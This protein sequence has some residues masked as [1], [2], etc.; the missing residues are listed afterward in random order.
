MKKKWLLPTIIFLIIGGSFFGYRTYSENVKQQAYDDLRK[1]WVEALTK[2]QFDQ[3]PTLVSEAS[4][5]EAKYTEEDLIA[6]YTNI[7]EGIELTN[8]QIDVKETEE[9]ILQYTASFD[10]AVGKIET[11]SYEAPIVEQGDAYKIDWDAALIFPSMHASDKVRYTVARPARGEIIDRNGVALAENGTRPQAGVIP[12]TLGTGALRTTKIA[13]IANALGITP[14]FV[15][16]QLAQSWVTEESFVPLKT[17]PTLDKPVIDGV[18]YQDIASRVYP[19][20]DIAAHLIGYVGKVTAEDIEKNSALSSNDIIGRTGLE[21]TFDD[22]LRGKKGGEIYIETAKGEKRETIATV[23]AVDGETIQLTIDT[24]L[25]RSAYESLGTGVGSTVVT[26]PTT[27]DILAA[28]SKPS[29]NP[30]LF[31]TGISQ[32]QY[33]IYNDD[34]RKPFISRFTARYAPGSTFKPITAAIGIEAGTL[35]PAEALSIPAM[36]WQPDKSWG[37]YFISRLNFAASVDLTTSLVKSDNIYYAIQALR[38][39]EEQFRAGLNKLIFGEELDLPV[40]MTPAQ[41][42]NDDKFSTSALLADTSYGQG[43][44]LL[45]PLQMA[46]T[47]S[48][49]PNDGTVVYPKLL[50]STEQKTKPAFQPATIATIE[51]ALTKVVTSADGTGHVLNSVPN[52]AAKTGTAELKATQQGRG[53]ENSLIVAYDT[54]ASRYLVVSIVENYTGTPSAAERIVPLLKS[55]Q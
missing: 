23:E 36:R 27:G 6:K 38:L 9:A 40:A 25:Q 7:F 43:Q 54:A 46:A 34:V 45:S 4:L 2:A 13:L 16:A 53:V 18:V 21:R 17:M 15:E 22:R 32:A 52:V 55:M 8:L 28:V 39:G 11:L 30:N 19:Y 44:M 5:K 37:S 24:F 51:S 3:L 26:E 20:A 31:V 29:F 50:K 14:K 47:Y 48:V 12:N 1:D 10:T 49:L 42:S 41:I 35:N 33:A